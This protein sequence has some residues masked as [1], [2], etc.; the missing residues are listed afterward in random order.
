M[1]KKI[2]IAGCLAVVGSAWTAAPASALTFCPTGT[3]QTTM[4]GCVTFNS[5]DQA[6]GNAIADA[7]QGTA[8]GSNFNVFY[9][10]NLNT[11]QFTDSGGTTLNTYSQGQLGSFFTFVLGYQEQFNG[12]TSAGGTNDLHFS[13]SANNDLAINNSSSDPNFFYMYSVGASG[14]NNLTGTNFVPTAGAPNPILSGHTVADAYSATFSTTGIAPGDLT[15]ECGALNTT[16]GCLDQGGAS[17]T[18]G[19]GLNN[20]PGVNTLNGTGSTTITI[21]IDTFNAAYFPDLPVGTTIFFNTNTSNNMPYEQIDPSQCF[22]ST[23]INNPTPSGA[24]GCTGTGSK[25][26]VGSVGAINGLSGPNTMFQADA[27][28]AFALTPGTVPEPA[29]LTLLGI[30]LLGS[31]AARRRQKKSKK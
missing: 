1:F 18:A 29:T 25:V 21:I 31:A 2:L 27:N 16:V 26:G 15:G 8:V 23:G 19:N 10:A 24:L 9:Q 7:F 6:P 30:G 4:V 20:Y 3:G 14:G 28:S 17:G 5:I 12:L 11:F 13:Y 22:S